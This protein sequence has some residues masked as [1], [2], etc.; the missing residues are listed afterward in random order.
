MSAYM[1]LVTE[2]FAQV[3][4]ERLLEIGAPAGEYRPEIKT[5]CEAIEGM[6]CMTLEGIFEACH[7]CMATWFGREMYHFGGADDLAW[8]LAARLNVF[9]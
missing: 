7:S 9:I 4:P 1:G 2:V 6:R 3:D 5:V 8:A